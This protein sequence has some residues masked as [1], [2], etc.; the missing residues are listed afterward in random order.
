MVTH[1]TFAAEASAAEPPIRG[2][3]ANANQEIYLNS[4][5]AYI[6]IANGDI[7]IHAPGKIDI[8]GATHSFDGPTARGYVLPGLP[9]TGDTLRYHEQ[10]RLVDENGEE[11][12]AHTRYEIE[13]ESGKTWSGFSDA[14]GLTQHIYTD[15]P[16]SLSLTV[17]KEIDDDSTKEEA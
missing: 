13:S 16:E 10:F 9:H 7:Q 15:Q 12:L 5:G 6:R 14:E 1:R 3:Q 2:P 11:V 8:K 4:G 17:Y